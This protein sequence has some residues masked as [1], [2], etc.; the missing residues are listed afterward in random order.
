[1]ICES[2]SQGDGQF[3]AA[4][5]CSKTTQQVREEHIVLIHDKQNFQIGKRLIVPSDGSVG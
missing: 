2:V 1:M 3:G 5:A 4:Q